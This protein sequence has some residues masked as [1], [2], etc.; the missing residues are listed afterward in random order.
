[1]YIYIYAAI[2]I[3]KAIKSL[4]STYRCLRLSVMRKRFHVGSAKTTSVV[5]E[6]RKLRPSHDRAALEDLIISADNRTT[7][8]DSAT[9]PICG[10]F[11]LPVSA[12]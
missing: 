4:I 2:C 5:M 9:T 11:V 7:S 12:T 8:Q 10:R 1:M 6:C 3:Y